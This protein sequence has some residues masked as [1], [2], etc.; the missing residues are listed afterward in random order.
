MKHLRLYGVSSGLQ[1]HIKSEDIIAKSLFDE[2]SSTESAESLMAVA[3]W[4]D[5]I[6]EYQ[7]IT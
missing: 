3:K 4:F 5:A 7:F 2:Q 6:Q 1:K